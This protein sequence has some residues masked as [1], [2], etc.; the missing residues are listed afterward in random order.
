MRLLFPTL[1][2]KEGGIFLPAIQPVAGTIE[3][4]PG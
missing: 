4:K 2:L 1:P 3:I